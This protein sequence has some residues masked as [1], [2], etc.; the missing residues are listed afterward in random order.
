L[1][2]GESYS[3][4]VSCVNAIE[5]V[6]KAAATATVDDTTAT[7]ARTK[8][9]AAKKAKTAKAAGKIVPARAA[10]TTAEVAAKTGKAPGRAAV[11][12]AKNVAPRKRASRRT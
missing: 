2:T 7:P 11:G 5:S 12:T 10:K 1:A 4:K 9:D 8:T 3:R 6:R